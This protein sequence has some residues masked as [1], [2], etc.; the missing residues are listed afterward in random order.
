MRV[1][2]MDKKQHRIFYVKND[3]YGKY[4]VK[5]EEI[6][7]FLDNCK[8]VKDEYDLNCDIEFMSVYGYRLASLKEGVIGC[9]KYSEH[10]KRFNG[11]YYYII[12]DNKYLGNVMDFFS[13]YKTKQA[14]NTLL[15]LDNSGLLESELRNFCADTNLEMNCFVKSQRYYNDN[16]QE[17]EIVFTLSERLILENKVY[18]D[19]INGGIKSTLY[20]MQEYSGYCSR[21]KKYHS[22]QGV[23]SEDIENDILSYPVFHEHRIMCLSTFVLK[24]LKYINTT[25]DKEENNPFIKCIAIDDYGKCIYFGLQYTPRVDWNIVVRYNLEDGKS[26]NNFKQNVDWDEFI[27]KHDLNRIY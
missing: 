8:T 20:Q 26:D 1:L 6:L 2:G 23:L 14:K 22:L 27:I 19:E 10:P 25:L 7:D 9:I 11:T 3:K 12:Y 15:G 4:I 16:N 17:K 21:Y 18:K 24:Y 13:K 5:S